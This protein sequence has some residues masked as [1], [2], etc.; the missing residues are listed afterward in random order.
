VTWLV[1]LEK[2]VKNLEDRMDDVQKLASGTDQEVA[3]WR[4]TLNNHTTTLNALRADQVEQGK[5]LTRVEKE[6]YAGFHQINENFAKVDEHFTT[7]DENFAKIDDH[8]TT[9]DENFATVE[10]KFAVLERGQDQI[11]KLLTR[12]LGGP[13]E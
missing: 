6:M 7:A 4:T 9:V 13:G 12:H 10:K 5:R 3:G 2:R 11:T 1:R 8:F